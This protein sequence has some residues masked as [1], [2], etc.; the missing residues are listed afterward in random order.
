MSEWK[1]NIVEKAREAGQ[2]FYENVIS[3]AGET[4]KGFGERLLESIQSVGAW[5]KDMLAKGGEAIQ[6]F[7][8]TILD[9]LKALPKNVVQTGKDIVTGLWNGISNA[10]AWILGKIRGFTQD[11]LG[12]IKDF[13]SGS[14]TKTGGG[15]T[16]TKA[17]PAALAV[18]AEEQPTAYAVEPDTPPS[19]TGGILARGARMAYTAM[20]TAVE[21]IS[22]DASE[23]KKTVGA[24]AAGLSGSG[25]NA[26]GCNTGKAPQEKGGNTYITNFHQTNNSPKALSRLEVYRQTKNALQYAAV[27]KG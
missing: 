12:S 24:S 6:K 1:E 14:E 13:F 7:S 18:Y 4:V 15:Q 22:V 26:S 23:A 19:P 21:K 11:V 27:Q 2:G 10:K 17:A 20:R 9:K 16:K 5:E 25:D 8:K 3:K